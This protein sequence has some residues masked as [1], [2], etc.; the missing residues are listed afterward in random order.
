[1]KDACFSMLS[2]GKSSRYACYRIDERSSTDRRVKETEYW[3]YHPKEKATEDAC[4][5]M[6]SRGNTSR[7]ACN[8][9]NK[10]SLTKRC[11]KGGTIKEAKNPPRE[12]VTSHKDVGDGARRQYYTVEQIMNGYGRDNGNKKDILRSKTRRRRE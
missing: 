9:I 3:E 2:T 5:S 12:K 8:R 4:L 1:M 10:R 7:Y 11:V 6:L